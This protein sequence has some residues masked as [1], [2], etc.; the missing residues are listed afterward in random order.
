MRNK[1]LFY[2]IALAL[3]PCFIQS[4]AFAQGSGNM[5]VLNGTNAYL[6]SGEDVNIVASSEFLRMEGW[7]KFDEV[8]KAVFLINVAN[9]DEGTAVTFP[10]PSTQAP[11]RTQKALWW[12]GNT[13][14]LNIPANRFVVT[15]RDNSGLFNNGGGTCALPTP[16]RGLFY[17]FSFPFTP[18]PNVWYHLAAVM[19]SS[20]PSAGNVQVEMFVNGIALELGGI[21]QTT[22][23]G[24]GG[25]C[26]TTTAAFTNTG[27]LTAPVAAAG[28]VISDFTYGNL[29]GLR[30]TNLFIGMRPDELSAGNIYPGSGIFLF[31]GQVDQVRLAN[32]PANQAGVRATMCDNS[33]LNFATYTFDDDPTAMPI[34]FKDTGTLPSQ[35][36]VR[37]FGGV[38]QVTSSAPI[39][40]VSAFTYGTNTVGIGYSTGTFNIT[41]GTTPTLMHV[42]R[43]NASPN[44]VTLPTQM[45]NFDTQYFGIFT[46][47]DNI[48]Y[49]V[50]YN[51]GGTAT[52]PNPPNPMTSPLALAV[53]RRLRNDAGA[54]AFDATATAAATTHTITGLTT[55]LAAAPPTNQQEFIYGAVSD[56]VLANIETPPAIPAIT[57]IENA[58][59]IPITNNTTV[60]YAGFLTSGTVQITGNYQNGEDILGFVNGNY[61]GVAFT[62]AFTALTGL[63]TITPTVPNT[64][65]AAAMQAALRAVTYLNNSENPN[66]AVRTVTFRVLDGMKQ[67]NTQ[68]RNINVTSVNDVPTL[69]APTCT[70]LTFTEGGIAQ[71]ILTAITANDLDNTTLSTAT[72]S[73]TNIQAGDIL[74]FT[75]IGGN[76]VTATG[77]AGSALTLTANGATHAQM[78]AALASV[79]FSNSSQNPITTQRNI[80]FTVS[81]GLLSSTPAITCTMNV[82][83]VNNPPTIT[84]TTT[85]ITYVKL[86]PA[87][88]VAPSIA[89]AD[90][91][92]T[93]I[94]GAVV[95]I[96]GFT[97]AQD[98][99]KF[100][101]PLP[102]GITSGDINGSGVATA[103]TITFTGVAT[104]A[105]YRALLASLTYRNTSGSPAP[106]TRTVAFQVTDNA[107]GTGVVA[108]RLANAVN[109]Q[110]VINIDATFNYAPTLDAGCPAAVRTFTELDTKTDLLNVMGLDVND[111]IDGTLNLSKAEFKITAGFQTGDE[112]FY[113][114]DLNPLPGTFT[115]TWDTPMTPRTYTL[116][117]VNT[118]TDYETIAARIKFKNNN[119]DNP[120]AGN[121]TITVQF[122][123]NGFPDATANAKGTSIC[124]ITLNVVPVNTAPVLN[125]PTCTGNSF[126]E[127]GTPVQ[128]LAINPMTPLISDLDHTSL[129]TATIRI[130]NTQAGDVLSFTPIV[131]NPVT[132]N[133]YTVIAGV[134]TIVLNANGATHAQ[135]EAAIANVRFSNTSSNPNITQRNISFVVNDG[136]TI[137]PT[138]LN[139]NIVNCQ[140]DITPVNDPPVLADI[141]TSILQYTEDDPAKQITN[142]ITAFDV[143][144]LNLV[145][146]TIT[147]SGNFASGEDVLEFTAIAGNPVGVVGSSTSTNGTITLSLPL[148]ATGTVAQFQA[149]LRSVAY[150]NSSQNPTAGL[151]TISF[152]VNDGSG[153]VS[154]TNLGSNSNIVTRQINVIPVNDAPV[155]NNPSPI[156]SY[157]EN[158]APSIISPNITASDIDNTNFASASIRITGNYFANQDVLGFTNANGITG[159]WNVNNATLTLTGSASLANYQTALQSITYTNTSENPSNLQRTVTITVNDGTAN[160]NAV[161]QLINVTPVNDPPVIVSFRR[162][163]NINGTLRLTNVAFADAYTDIENDPIQRII[164][165]SLPTRGNLTF[166]GNPVTAGQVIPISNLSI[167]YT[168]QKDFEGNDSFEWRALDRPTGMNPTDISN[169][170]NA[171]I[172]VR[173]TDLYPPDKLKVQ[174]GS[175][176]I[177]LSWEGVF[178]EGLQ[179]EYEV[180][181]ISANQPLKFV[182]KTNE[183]K[184]LITGLENT[185]TYTFRVVA[186]DNLDRRSGFSD[187]ISGRPSIILGAEDNLEAINFNLFPN[188]NVGDFVLQFEEKQS[189]KA[190]IFI[191]NTVGQRV[192]EKEIQSVSGR[193]EE[194]IAASVLT[195]GT[196]ILYIQTGDKHYQKRFVVQK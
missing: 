142:T 3:L 41:A 35:P 60:T 147:I 50:V 94:S 118:I 157:T 21:L 158:D 170:A 56:P 65:T 171:N 26:P 113:G 87:I 70:A 129:R 173:L 119:V 125:A 151:R 81:D 88:S 16:M 17:D 109:P 145:T 167:I 2:L 62:G 34:G 168:P 78:S 8:T 24:T 179:V 148:M 15:F 115:G 28:S 75:P 128:I 72:I 105:S 1:F 155:L 153:A 146:A 32:A 93:Q 122:F 77:G 183:E 134:G 191:F 103:G 91:D 160:S 101:V 38:T 163:M 63:M 127:K 84:G 136:S 156:L 36:P 141:E 166:N 169:L 14:A 97:V 68:T 181:V 61:G 194:K 45:G 161:T 74:S 126:I 123:D 9:T 108:N 133:A 95:T 76:P 69:T 52:L 42:Y 131:G 165:V 172:Q 188:P 154:I 79:F 86:A 20:T 124:S 57:Y 110:V 150:R 190:Q 120:P 73:I 83:A 178:V 180:Y 71:Q 92:D 25:T 18:L 49:N 47:T 177:L 137:A 23:G 5:V 67:S 7:F 175:K 185:V 48:T 139:S 96:T 82:A 90:V 66:T 114:D 106:A 132:A 144:N 104:I 80:N 159:T 58:G 31:A 54:F 19:N 64:G 117:G 140:I 116:S 53:A 12:S 89:L 102:A 100:T 98:E 37:T 10:D 4:S 40:N 130:T 149:A 85:P 30:E 186:V 33:T 6:Q 27:T 162:T 193:Y 176:Q 195:E 111:N 189:K 138:N 143:D 121:R 196:Y 46:G 192:F 55:N 112:L 99:F 182:A 184:L 152:V 44:N 13:G 43:V 187:P 164:I 135:L 174:V 29:G 22:P 51:H 11:F 59:A 107:T 39:G